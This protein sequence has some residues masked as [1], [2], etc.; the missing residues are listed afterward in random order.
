M[1]RARYVF[2]HEHDIIRKGPE[3]EK[4]CCLTNYT[5][6]LGSWD[7][8]LQLASSHGVSNFALWTST[9]KP[10][11]LNLFLPP[12]YPV[13]GNR[14]KLLP[15]NF[16][17]CLKNLS[18]YSYRHN[19]TSQI[20]SETILDE[21][22]SQLFQRSMP[23]TPLD[24]TIYSFKILDRTLTLLTS[25]TWQRYLILPTFTIHILEWDQ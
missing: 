8:H 25:L 11:Q 2:L 23:Q 18:K 22:K 9:T 21:L 14:G 15:Q 16:K 1:G 17:V 6:T 5:S 12:V 10:P 13:G 19:F 4:A 7:S 20:A 3:N 24:N